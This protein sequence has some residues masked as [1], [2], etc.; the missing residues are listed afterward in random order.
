MAEVI[1]IATASDS[2]RPGVLVPSSSDYRDPSDVLRIYL[3]RLTGLDP[4]L[5][6]KRWLRRPGT[7]PEV[8]KDWAA[9]GVDR[10]TTAGYPYQNASKS[11]D[12]ITRTSW[13]TLRCIASFYGENAAELADT[14]REGLLIGQNDAQ[15]RKFGLTIQGIEGDVMHLPDLLFEQWID[16]YDVVFNLNRS[17][18]RTYDVRTITSA[19]IELITEKGTLK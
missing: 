4:K 15:L 3:S 2:T 17:V 5:V 19:N 16:R 11:P 10:I 7:Q 6:R 13:Q 9:V 14:F 12:V 1:K 8:G 18:T